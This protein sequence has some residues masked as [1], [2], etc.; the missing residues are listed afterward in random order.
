[1]CMAKWKLSN[2]LHGSQDQYCQYSDL[3][4]EFECYRL[5]IYGGR[6]VQNTVGINANNGS[7]KRKTTKTTL[8]NYELFIA[9]LV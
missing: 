6:E 8:V 9:H 5:G 4:R 3:V 2:R 1:M 7:N